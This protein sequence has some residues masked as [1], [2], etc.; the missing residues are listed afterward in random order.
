MKRNS[1]PH[2]R[3]GSSTQRN[4]GSYG[5]ALGR[6]KAGVYKLLFPSANRSTWALCL[7]LPFGV[8]SGGGMPGAARRLGLGSKLSTELATE[9]A[10]FW[11]GSAGPWP[12]LLAWP[13]FSSEQLGRRQRVSEQCVSASVS[14]WKGLLSA[15]PPGHVAANSSPEHPALSRP[16]LLPRAT[17]C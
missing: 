9:R 10:W 3:L 7:L 5:E 8:G 17:R 11:G 12:S 14:V 4:D 2:P 1:S 16:G 6:A 15:A 13:I